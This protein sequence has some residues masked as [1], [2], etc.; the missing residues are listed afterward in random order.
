ME[1]QQLK[2]MERVTHPELAISGKIEVDLDDLRGDYGNNFNT[3][4]I[5]NTDTSTPIEIYLDGIKV[6]YVTANNG[7]FA[8]D[9]EYGIKYNFLSIENTSGAV[10][11]AANKVKITCGRSGV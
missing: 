3:L 1:I 10:V 11:I 9:W 2:F 6:A 8:F 4:I 5:T 7:T